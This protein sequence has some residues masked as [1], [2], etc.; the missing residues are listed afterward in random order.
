MLKRVKCILLFTIFVIFGASGMSSLAMDNGTL[1]VPGAHT[2]ETDTGSE[3]PQAT[4]RVVCLDDEL[5]LFGEGGKEVLLS[6]FSLSEMLEGF[7]SGKYYLEGLTLKEDLLI[8]QGE[9]E[10]SGSLTLVGD[11][12]IRQESSLSL[13]GLALSLQ[14]SQEGIRVLGG[15]LIVKASSVTLGERC[16]MGGY[17]SSSY[18]F[19]S[20]SEIKSSSRD[21]TITQEMGCLV[22]NDGTVKN[23]NGAA[24][25]N[26]GTV[27]LSGRSLLLGAKYD[28]VTEQ[29]IF[30][31]YNGVPLLSEIRLQ[32]PMA[33]QKGGMYEIARTCTSDIT[34]LVRVFDEV[35][36]E[37]SL[38]YFES[39]EGVVEKCF[40][41]VYLPYTVRVFDS[42]ILIETY[43]LLRGEC[44][45]N[46][47]RIEK[48]G[49]SHSGWYLDESLSEELSPDMP[50]TSDLDVYAG[51]KLLLPEFSI[52]SVSFTF[53]QCE[54]LLDFS[55]LSH[56]L[57]ELGFYK[58]EWFYNDES[59]GYIDGGISL[60][61]TS[62]SGEYYCVITFYYGKDSVTV[63]TAPVYVNISKRIVDLPSVVGAVYNGKWQSA[64]VAS[65]STYTVWSEGGIDAGVY[66]VYFSLRDS[67]N[68]TFNG[69]TDATVIIDFV[70]EKSE[71]RFIEEL[72]ALSTY[73]NFPITPFAQAEFGDVIYRYSDRIDGTYSAEPP[74]LVGDYF[75]VAEILE[76]ENYYGIIS[77][78]VAFS[79]IP[80]RPITLSVKAPPHKT[81]YIAFEDFLSEGLMLEVLYNSGR[82]ETVGDAAAVY[83]YQTASELRYGDNAVIAE[84]LGLS[85]IVS[86][87][88]SKAK[89]DI[90]GISFP[91]RVVV[92]DGEYHTIEK[93]EALP[94]GKD[95]IPLEVRITG[96]A[97]CVG[98]HKVY[99]EFLSE[100]KN[101]II[102]DRIEATLVIE[103]LAVEVVWGTREFVYDGKSK[104]PLAY[105]INERGVSVPLSVV[106]AAVN[107]TDSAIAEAIAPGDNYLLVNPTVSFKVKKADFDLSGV[108]WSGKEIAYRGEYV[109]VTL[110][111]LPDGLV[112][113]GYT[114][115]Y[116]S[117]VGTYLARAILSYDKRNYNPPEIDAYSWSIIPAQY[118]I[119][120]IVFKDAS[121]VYDGEPHYPILLG[122]MPIGLD[123]VMLEYELSAGATHASEEAYEIR[124][125]FKTTSKSYTAPD[126]LV[127]YVKIEPKEISVIWEYDIAV[128]DGQV[129]SPTAHSEDCLIIVS[130]G[131]VSAGAY[132]A[133]AKAAVSDYRIINDSFCYEIKKGVNHFTEAPDIKDF[134]ESASPTPTGKAVEGEIEFLYYYDR[135]CTRQAY[136]P[137]SHGIYYMRAIA[138]EG[139]N[140]TEYISDPIELEVLEVLP[141]GIEAFLSKAVFRAFE[142]VG[143][144]DIAL[145]VIYND[146]EREQVPFSEIRIDYPRAESLR[147]GD[148]SV[149]VSYGGFSL[150]C[151][152]AVERAEYDLSGVVWENTECIYDG[153]IRYPTLVGLPEG[154]SVKEYLGG[155]RDVGEYTVS[156]TFFY[157]EDNYSQPSVSPC[158]IRI[159]PLTV[160]L[161]MLPS[162]V[163][164]GS[165]IEI[166]SPSELYDVY[167]GEIINAGV[168]TVTLRLKDGKNH[169]FETGGDV[170]EV[171]LTVE[172]LSVP[173][174]AEDLTLYLFERER[175]P[176]F[177]FTDGEHSEKELDIYY[178]VENGF[179]YI[180]SGNENYVIESAPVRVIRINRLSPSLRWW[181]LLIV[182]VNIILLLDVIILI[183]YKGR[184]LDMLARIRCKRYFEREAEVSAL[185][186][187]Q[188]Y[189][190]PLMQGSHYPD[191]KLN[192]ISDAED[193]FIKNE[194]EVMTVN[195]QRADSLI[196]DSL[197]KSLLRRER[198]VVYT[199]GNKK[200]VVNV[201]IL[202]ESFSSGDVINVNDMKDKHI[203]SQDTLSVKVLARGRI[204][205]PLLVK[206]NAFSLAA[207]KMIALSGGEAIK[208]TSR[209]DKSEGE[210]NPVA[211]E[212]DKDV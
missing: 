54:H 150:D 104:L 14:G 130:G 34:T 10:L 180:L 136:L 44:P 67:E 166:I 117:E 88:V 195:V 155:G 1:D 129:H 2:V 13:N 86:V 81:E 27:Y 40:A 9:Y 120:G 153:G 172:R 102:P 194:D 92:Y 127:A 133:Y 171:A 22:L 174:K 118:D 164:C 29:P 188:A 59:I 93:P 187:T 200:S 89:Y 185:V 42:D 124:L 212:K 197:A 196:S 112:V 52:S 141:V 115:N 4:Y 148:M 121:Y 135:G 205:K 38:T 107:A 84:Y 167:Y 201:D 71:N 39:Y 210:K 199:S 134:Y 26:K 139:E 170:A 106:G 168:Y 76:T 109:S 79:I 190:D 176:D 211:I 114:D 32:Y 83:R 70:I 51:Y 204:D 123:G 63:T 36:R 5:L 165:A 30:F 78:P 161:P 24:I 132:T 94:Y 74:T 20:D 169:I 182:F 193:V 177:R 33:L 90:S 61:N 108:R 21:A 8:P 37:Y 143:A 158:R 64:D 119:S 73:A 183:K 151:E 66:P 41:A 138:P 7:G 181:V 62:D 50:I 192:E 85:A 198:E 68:Y 111:D 162:L 122:E 48:K 57:D 142:V 45:K 3:K 97:S 202:S 110:T 46:L 72:S 173:I 159:T 116:A 175:M 126:P 25:Y 65:T 91:S 160:S 100:S 152:L 99:L 131:G 31:S 179:I 140:Y 77:S 105:F 208:V 113:I 15:S 6:A 184:I 95:G 75:V 17:S 16:I 191:I 203:V 207:V 23:D 53:D 98:T 58:L 178:M 156:V 101:Y 128:Y 12:I 43:S 154:V 47:K 80:E 144:E 19:I 11:I 35:G 87:S 60:L 18:L 49:Y 96:G 189:D 69:S 55:Y 137:L 186:N 56:P 147:Y 28:I 206:A 82:S 163:F 209:T 149:R 157:D 145:F 125:I 146:G 103:P